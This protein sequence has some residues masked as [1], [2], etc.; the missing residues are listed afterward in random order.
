M[1]EKT[2]DILT[3]EI[4]K[5][6]YEKNLEALKQ[7]QDAYENGIELK[8]CPLCEAV[9]ECGVCVWNM[10]FEQGESQ[11]EL[12]SS[13]FLYQCEFSASVFRG[14]VILRNETSL[15]LRLDHLLEQRR[16]ILRKIEELEK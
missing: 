7:L 12:C 3:R 1:S 6:L 2:L 10:M 14:N 5:D 11:Y 13:F 9:Y 8:H 15:A 16:F 4:L